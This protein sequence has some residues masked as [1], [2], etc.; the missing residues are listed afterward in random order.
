ML[1]PFQVEDDLVEPLASFIVVRILFDAPARSD[2]LDLLGN[3]LEDWLRANC[4]TAPSRAV[5]PTGEVI[6]VGDQ[7]V[8]FHI[9]AAQGL[10]D[11]ILPSMLKDLATL[12]RAKQQIARVEMD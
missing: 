2:T 12:S 1:L 7:T 6:H 8:E 4:A 9:Y 11:M 3:I 5:S 10:P